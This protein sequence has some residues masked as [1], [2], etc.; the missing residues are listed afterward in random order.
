[1][2]C[3]RD[4][5]FR[6]TSAHV[7]LSIVCDAY[8]APK[9][10]Y[11]Q[12]GVAVFALISLC[13]CCCAHLTLRARPSR[14]PRG[15][16]LLCEKAA[17][18]LGGRGAFLNKPPRCIF[19]MNALPTAYGAQSAQSEVTCSHSA[20]A[21]PWAAVFRSPAAQRRPRGARSGP[22]SRRSPSG[23]SRGRSASDPRR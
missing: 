3:C 11:Q 18:G 12:R 8:T 10:K 23:R 1:M 2:W 5:I 7:E 16:T 14:H 13:L 17:S 21:C 4:Q 15:R 22:S 20:A 19:M 9:A 6:A